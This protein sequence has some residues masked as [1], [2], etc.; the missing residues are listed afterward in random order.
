MC[1]LVA[2]HRLSARDISPTPHPHRNNRH[3]NVITSHPLV[4]LHFDHEVKNVECGNNHLLIQLHPGADDQPKDEW[5]TNSLITGGVHFMCDQDLNKD[6][7][8]PG[9]MHP[10][11]LRRIVGVPTALGNQT[12]KLDTISDRRATGSIHQAAVY[13]RVVHANQLEHF[14]TSEHG[15]ALLREYYDATNDGLHSSRE[16]L[17]RRKLWGNPVYRAA[18]RGIKKVVKVAKAVVQGAALVSQ[19]MSNGKI[20]LYKR[21]TWSAGRFNYNGHGGAQQQ[22]LSLASGYGGQVTCDNCYANAEVGLEFQLILESAPTSGVLLRVALLSLAIDGSIRAGADVNLDLKSRFRK[23]ITKQLTSPYN[24][25][26]LN[27]QAGPIPITIS[28][29][30]TLYADLTISSDVKATASVGFDYIK[31]MKFGAAYRGSSVRKIAHN[32]SAQFNYHP[33]EMEASGAISVELKMIPQV[34][35]IITSTSH[36]SYTNLS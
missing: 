6:R 4:N 23:T 34:R 14:N 5:A 24:L 28:G 30:C 16:Y 31:T 29:K 18:K 15:S 21:K 27:F 19:L 20:E 7:L 35:V 17:H 2:L 22:S 9:E 12:Y 3:Y 1:E 10:P 36:F 26:T 11:F 13:T 32:P 8:V 25:G 33:F